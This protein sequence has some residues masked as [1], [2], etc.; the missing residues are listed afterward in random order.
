MANTTTKLKI[1]AF[2]LIELLVVI[3]IIAVLMAILMPAM[4]KARGQARRVHCM[5]NLKNIG[6]GYHS[7]A[8]ENDDYF[9]SSHVLGGHNFRVQKGYIMP[10]D[11]RG[12][13]EIFG[14]NALFD[15]LKI[16]DASDKVWV[17]QDIGAKWM[18]PYGVTYAFSTAAIL[19]KTKYFK[20]SARQFSKSPLCWDNFTSLPGTPAIPGAPRGST[21]PTERRKYPHNYHTNKSKDGAKSIN[22]L[23]MDCQVRASYVDGDT[24]SSGL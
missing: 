13:K 3:S 14:L 4:K 23:F 19:A 7:Y 22:F 9:P 24:S 20:F 10:N 17:C 18:R 5:A 8:M 21:V 16:I 6:V 1:K 11:P 2:T 12:N 15:D